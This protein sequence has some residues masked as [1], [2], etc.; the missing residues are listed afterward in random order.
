VSAGAEAAVQRTRSSRGPGLVVQLD[1][2]VDGPI[3]AIR[4]TVRLVANAAAR[5]D[6]WKPPSGATR[7]MEGIEE[8]AAGGAT[9]R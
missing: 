8:D 7:R 3:K 6:L 9:S 2:E 1:D 4:P 5:A